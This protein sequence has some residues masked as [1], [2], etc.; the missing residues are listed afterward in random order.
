MKGAK[1]NQ[2]FPFHFLSA[3]PTPPAEE[4]KEG[5]KFFGFEFA[6]EA[7]VRGAKS[8]H[9]LRAWIISQNPADFA[10]NTFEL[11]P[12]HTATANPRASALGFAVAETAGRSQVTK[13]ISAL[14]LKSIKYLR[15]RLGD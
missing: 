2:K 7:S 5:R 10:R 12:I 11:C 8:L 6:S 15:P 14:R 4:G 13:Y 1:Q 9:A 3:P